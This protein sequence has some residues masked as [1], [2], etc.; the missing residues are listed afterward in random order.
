MGPRDAWG[1]W[2]SRRWPEASVGRVQRSAGLAGEGLEGRLGRGPA[3][4][5]GLV[6]V[7]QSP[8]SGLR[9]ALGAPAA[10]VSVSKVGNEGPVSVTV[11]QSRGTRRPEQAPQSVPT[12]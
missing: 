4:G 1:T 10:G 12:G 2:G 7:V 3:G 11:P 5:T 6:W 9:W 8:C